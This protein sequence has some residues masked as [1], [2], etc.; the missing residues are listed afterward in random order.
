[1]VIVLQC[2]SIASN[3]ERTRRGCEEAK[4][5]KSFT[6][7]HL[8]IQSYLTWMLAGWALV[9]VTFVPFCCCCCCCKRFD[10]FLRCKRPCS[11]SIRW[12]T[13][14]NSACRCCKA[15]R[16]R[17]RRASCWSDSWLRYCWVGWMW[18]VKVM[19]LLGL[20]KLKSWNSLRLEAK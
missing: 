9:F 18:E 15:S 7:K 14:R 20:K 2:G 10:A 8:R 3:R 12:S 6:I 16:C 19:F 1:M 4:P 5:R 13:E 17:C 11:S